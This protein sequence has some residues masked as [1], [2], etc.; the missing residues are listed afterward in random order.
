MKKIIITI[1]AV[2]LAASQGLSGQE[3]YRYAQRDTCD[4]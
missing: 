3:V 1:L 4:L 2:L